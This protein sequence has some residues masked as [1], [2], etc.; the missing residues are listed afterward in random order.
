MDDLDLFRK[1]VLTRTLSLVDKPY[2]EWRT[3]NQKINTI[4]FFDNENINSSLS[5]SENELPLLECKLKNSYVLITTNRV[6][7]I[8]G[9]EIDEILISTISHF[10]NE[11]ENENL[12]VVNG[13][14]PKINI[15][16]LVNSKEE[17]LIFKI[18]SLY[19]AY[20]SKILIHNLISIKT[21]GSYSW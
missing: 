14:G 19:P 3:Y 18:D 2:K 4:L 11:F 15:I 10:G 17:K 5:L 12:K 8:L 6:V 7:S 21:K 13:K 9:T 20:F 1:E 16:V